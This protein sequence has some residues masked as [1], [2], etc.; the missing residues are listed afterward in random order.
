MTGSAIQVSVIICT[1]RRDKVLVE[2]IDQVL[3]QIDDVTEVLIVDQK[4]QHDL[5]T[6]EY[7]KLKSDQGAIRYFN[8]K[9]SGLTHAR[10]FGATQARG[11][12]LLFCDDDVLPCASWIREH[13]AVYD[14]QRVSA[15]AGQ[16]LNVGQ[17]ARNAPNSFGHNQP[18]PTYDALHGANFSVR[19][20]AY[21]SVGGS[22]E[23]LG[24]HAYTE[25]L[26]L[27]HRLLKGG[28]RISFCPSASVIHLMSSSGGCRIS[29]QTQQ[30]ME[31]EKPFSKLYWL[32]LNPPNKRSQWLQLLWKAARHGPLRKDVVVR[33]WRQPA[34]WLGFVTSYWKARKVVRGRQ[35]L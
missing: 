24:V 29:D 28:H 21:E 26:I 16:V 32:H 35:I 7:L 9:K 14:D 25:D 31:W 33:F 13:F 5:A 19:K 6:C 30:T 17:C 12:V 15:V 3:T 1:Y 4:A 10:N 8:I 22:D 27:A 11:A 2:T 34:A 23:N 20:T 18:I